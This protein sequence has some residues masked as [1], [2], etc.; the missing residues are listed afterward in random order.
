MSD[1]RPK[2]AGPSAVSEALPA[3]DLYVVPQ[4][5]EQRVSL[6]K[7]LERR[8]V[9]A[10]ATTELVALILGS[11]AKRGAQTLI[12]RHGLAGI[13]GLSLDELQAAPRV[14]RAGAAQL[15]AALELYRRLSRERSHDRNKLSRPRDVFREV[16]DL[17]R[18]R[19]E[20]LVGLYLDAQN[21]LLHRETLSIGSLNT[22]RTH[23]REILF[24]AIQHGALGFIL[25]HN[26][27]SGCLDPS[28]EDIEF[29]RAVTRAGELMGI[30][31]YDH[32]IVSTTG[33]TSLRER[34]LL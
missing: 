19:K 3:R 13:E 14:G 9:T 33:Y 28:H 24:P 21:G 22:T 15:A 26:H 1:E 23:P 7:K 32:L 20:H 17:K 11:N 25:A 27:P 8:G 5:V 31:L 16:Q 29:T 30:E 10:L 4:H 18:A 34:G 12:R 6:R 2:K